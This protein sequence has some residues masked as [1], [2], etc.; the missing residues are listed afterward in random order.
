M[1]LGILALGIMAL[2]ILALG[3]MAL[4]ILALGIMALFILALVN[5]HWVNCHVTLQTCF[6]KDTTKA[7]ELKTKWSAHILQKSKGRQSLKN[8][9]KLQIALLTSFRLNNGKTIF[10]IM[11]SIYCHM[12]F[13]LTLSFK[14]S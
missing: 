14:L 2:G 13:R 6:Y 7:A 3:I 9:Y 8:A 12:L 4:G 1:A 10:A 5:W 11:T